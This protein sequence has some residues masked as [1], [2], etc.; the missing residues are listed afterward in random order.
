MAGKEPEKKGIKEGEKLMKVDLNNAE[1][2]TSTTMILNEIK[3]A[4]FAVIDFSLRVMSYV[5]G[6]VFYPFKLD[7]GIELR[8]GDR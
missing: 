8:M 3:W 7:C 4:V 2:Q 1:G 6:F 5:M